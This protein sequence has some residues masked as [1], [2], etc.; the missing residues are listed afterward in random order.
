MGFYFVGNEDFVL[1]SS[2]VIHYWQSTNKL[3]LTLDIKD[4]CYHLLVMIF[5]VPGLY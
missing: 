4:P 1:L 3:R 2:R 5:S